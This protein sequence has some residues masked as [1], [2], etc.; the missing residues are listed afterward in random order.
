MKNC[1]TAEVRGRV[2]VASSPSGLVDRDQVVPRGLAPSR[3]RRAWTRR[4]QRRRWTRWRWWRGGWAGELTRAVRGTST[5][6]ECEPV[7]LAASR[8]LLSN[9]TLTSKS[10][11]PSCLEWEDASDKVSP[12]GSRRTRVLTSQ[13]SSTERQLGKEDIATQLG[14]GVETAERAGGRI[15][16]SSTMATRVMVSSKIRSGQYFLHISGG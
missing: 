12:P 7:Y 10:C 14:T 6:S 8:A 5:A 4:W 11:P 1:P 13:R 3:D 16:R 15:T 9:Y 2:A